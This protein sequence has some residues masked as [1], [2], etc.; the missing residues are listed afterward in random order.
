MRTIRELRHERGW[1]QFD[2]AIKV[3][4][5][6]QTIYLWESGRRAPRVEHMR[7]LGQLFEISSDEIRLESL[8]TTPQATDQDHASEATKQEACP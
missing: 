4:V 2:L 1:T 7:K 5:Q 3:G 6:P 8:P